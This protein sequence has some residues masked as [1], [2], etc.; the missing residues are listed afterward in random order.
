MQNNSI[1]QDQ[2]K[3]NNNNVFMSEELDSLFSFNESHKESLKASIKIGEE[4][5]EK[6]IVS[7][8]VIDNLVMLKFYLSLEDI[9]KLETNEISSIEYKFKGKAIKTYNIEESEFQISWIQLDNK[10]EADI[11]INKRGA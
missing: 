9:I 5:L 1:I 2:V 8:T 10:Y 7:K 11:F 4:L 3:K 6:D